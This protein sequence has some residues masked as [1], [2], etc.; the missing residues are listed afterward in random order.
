MLQRLFAPMVLAILVALP[1]RAEDVARF[2]LPNGLEAVVIEDHRAPVVVHMMWYRTGAADEPPGKSG[3]AHFLE[4]LM[5]K[6]TDTMAPGEFSAT[7]EAQGG[8]D[9]AFTSWDYTAYFQRVAADR[10]DLM[11]RMEADR[12]RGLILSEQDVAT[13]RDVIL[14]ERNQRTDSDPGSLFGEQRRAALYLNHPYRLPIIGWRHEIEAL[15]R[16]DALEFYQT[17]YAPN[18][19]ILIVAGDVTPEEVRALAETHYGPIA[20]TPDLPPRIR[21]SE[22]P[23]LV[24][25]RL[26]M[27]DPRVAQP[28]VIRTYLAPQR[29]AG[30]Q[31]EAAAL[32]VLAEILGGNGTTSVMARALQFGAEAK[33]LYTAAFYDGNALD[34]GNFG[35]IIVPVPGVSLE[36][37]EAAMDAVVTRFLEDGVDKAEFERVKRQLRASEIYRRDDVEQLARG[38]GTALTTGLTVAD[39]QGWPAALQAVTVDD[40]MAAAQS[41]L[42]RRASVTGWLMQ[43]ETGTGDAEPPSPAPAVDPAPVQGEVPMK[44]DQGEGAQK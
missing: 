14:E 15:N 40:V 17:F 35:L 28:Y 10:L 21:P 41:V 26:A 30:D 8:D 31:A 22:P 43:E 20:P 23:H 36:D 13:E 42:D 1:V 44:T 32:T 38:Y 34:S 18:N 39:V 9:N 24:E 4:H 6:G 16:S 25:R 3:I 37:G 11:M 7:V 2:T 27:A 12:M 5:F 33:A 29:R 19:A